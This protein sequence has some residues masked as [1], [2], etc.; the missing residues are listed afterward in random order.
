MTSSSP[1][2]TPSVATKT[3]DRGESGLANGER[4]SKSSQVFSVIGDLDELN[5]QL[6]FCLVPLRELLENHRELLADNVKFLKKIQHTLYEISAEVARSPKVQVSDDFLEEL[7]TRIEALEQEMAEGW[8]MKFRYPGGTEGAARL[9]LARTM[10]RRV[11]RG[12]VALNELRESTD[13]REE[14]RPTLLQS[15]NRLSDYLYVLR[16]FVNQEQGYVD[17]FFEVE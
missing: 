7:D 16:C 12:M 11:E 14:L 9:D 4:L 17:E 6:G 10:C 15:I 1:S 3:G 13:D 5:S 2:S 8:M